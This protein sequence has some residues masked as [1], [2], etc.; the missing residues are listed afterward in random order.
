MSPQKTKKPRIGRPSI[1][2]AGGVSPVLQVRVAEKHL[3]LLDGLIEKGHVTSRP[4]AVRWVLDR[5]LDLG[6]GAGS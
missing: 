5:A 3:A 6:T 4:L 2:E 1:Q